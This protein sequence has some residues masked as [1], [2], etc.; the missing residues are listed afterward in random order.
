MD[1]VSGHPP[2][3]NY[4]GGTNTHLALG[5][6]AGD[7][8]EQD[9]SVLQQLSGSTV[10]VINALPFE[11]RLV[12]GNRSLVVAGIFRSMV[13]L[14]DCKGS[15]E[16]KSYR[17]ILL[18]ISK[19][20]LLDLTPR[21]ERKLRFLL[22]GWLMYCIGHCAFYEIIAFSIVSYSNN[23]PGNIYFT[24]WFSYSTALVHIE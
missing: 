6:S 23:L 13:M 16:K 3:V 11:V 18:Y 20:R 14:L 5:A 8:S 2:R 1:G 10:L 19:C 7:F 9:T 24:G 21:K 12:C 17:T 22:F 15:T 4:L